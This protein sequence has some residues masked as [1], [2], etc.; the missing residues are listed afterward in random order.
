MTKR[1]GRTSLCSGLVVVDIVSM[2]LVVK[3]Q[4]LGV[5]FEGFMTTLMLFSAL[6]V[7]QFICLVFFS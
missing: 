7:G 6:F 2:G 5:V 4:I 1:N 3:V